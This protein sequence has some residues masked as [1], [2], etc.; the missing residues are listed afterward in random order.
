NAA[1]IITLLE[2]LNEKKISVAVF[3]E[4]C[5]TGYTCGDL[6]LQD[7][8]LKESD[9]ALNKIRKASSGSNLFF[10]VGA[11]IGIGRRL[12]NC[13]VAM[14]NGRILRIVPKSYRPN[15]NEFYEKRWFSPGE[16]AEPIQAI[17][18]GA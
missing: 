4:L 13:A 17:S 12:Y 18:W 2:Q 3:P 16:L 1:A 14:Q 8:L 9:L 11:P 5:V 7:Q 10:A 6:F 15:S